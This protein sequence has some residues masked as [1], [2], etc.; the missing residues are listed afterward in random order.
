MRLTTGNSGISS[1]SWTKG[2]QVTCRCTALSKSKVFSCFF[3]LLDAVKLFMEE[4]DKDYP[5][6][7]DLEW[8]MD[9]AFSVDMLCHLDRLNLTLQGKL[10]MLPDL[11]QSVFAFVNKLKL[12]EAHIQKGDLTHF[13][14]LLKASEQVTSAALKKKRDRYATLVAN[15]HE[16]F[17]TRF[18]D[19]QLKRPQITFLVD[20]FNA[21]T[22]CLKAPLVTDEAAAELEMIDL[23]EEDQLKAVLREGTV[24]FWKTLLGRYNIGKVI[25]EGHYAV[26]KECVERATGKEYALKIIDK[27][28]WR[29][30]KRS[31]KN[32]VSVLRMVKHP[33]IIMLKEDFNLPTKLYLVMELVKGGDLY[34]TMTPAV[35]FTERDASGMVYNL[36]RALNYLHRRSIVHRDVK[37][38]NLLVFEHPDGTKTLKLGDFGLAMVV[39]GPL[40]TV[41]GTPT[42]LAPEIIAKIGYGLKV[43]I[44]AAGVITYILLCG[45]PPFRSECHQQ[46]D[47]FEQILKGQLE[48]PSP[49]WDPISHSIKELIVQMLQMNPEERFSAQEILSHPWIIDHRK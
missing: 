26:V 25:G 23:C 36:A 31:L 5:E 19:L 4:K 6:L 27:T 18:C 37:P 44:W 1:L 16:S 11:V 43:D 48:Y 33:N 49:Y 20:P 17:V 38:E 32:E 12:F 8:I 41:C 2:F 39:K 22:D 35:K 14:T 10:K 3:E 45:F 15:L 21:E 40:Y 9:L 46:E 7:S 24:E 28:K 13:H 34:N 30:I 47:L 29:G 42:Y